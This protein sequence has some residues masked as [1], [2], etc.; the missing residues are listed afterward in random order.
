M[1]AVSG[2]DAFLSQSQTK[3]SCSQTRPMSMIDASFQERTG[4]VLKY[5]FINKGSRSRGLLS[6]MFVFK[7][8][9]LAFIE[10]SPVR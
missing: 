10:Q 1:R 6:G 3:P 7:L 4:I 5:T 2:D 9:S 8:G